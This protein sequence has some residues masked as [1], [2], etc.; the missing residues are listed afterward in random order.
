MLYWK[1]NF[2]I[3]NSGTQAA[4]VYVKVIREESGIVAEYYSDPDL[5]NM[6]MNKQYDIDPNISDYENYLLTLEEYSLYTKI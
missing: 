2:N 5:S 6:I 3:P 1:A 4:E